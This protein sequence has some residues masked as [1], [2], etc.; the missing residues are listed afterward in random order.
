MR[1][2]TT[3]F[4]AI[5]SGGALV[6]ALAACG[7]D[8]PEVEDANNNGNNSQDEET[9]E[10]TNAGD[11]EGTETNGAEETDDAGVGGDDGTEETD[12]GLGGEDGAEETDEGTDGDTGGDA[13]GAAAGSEIDPQELVERLQ[14]PGEEALSSFEMNMDMNVEGQNV[15]MTGAADLSG[16]A[17]AMDIQMEMPGMGAIHMILADGSA[18]M[19]M[20]GMTEEG[21]FV[22]M[23]LEELMGEEGTD[24]TEQM[25][26]TGQ[27]DDWAN[28]QSVT[29]VGQEDVNGEQMDHYQLVL[30]TTQMEDSE[31]GMP[32]ELTYDVWVDSSDFMRMVSFDI[33]G[34][35]TEMTMDNWGEPVDI[36]AP[37]E[38]QLTEIPGMGGSTESP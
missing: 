30:D 20:P 19:S 4:G 38:S 10:D 2:T 9:T 22:E 25:D 5:V 34:S 37:D 31:A 27:W 12:D 7:D 29:L 26:M 11:D 3:R 14:S 1:R 32:P 33:D 24:L 13:G 8:S 35:V 17:P 23:P 16:S 18:Y 28:A 36:Q 6:L 21:Q 15:T